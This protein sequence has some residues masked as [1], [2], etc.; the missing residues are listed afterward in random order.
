MTRRIERILPEF[1]D[2]FPRPMKTGVL[3]ISIP[4][5]TCGHLCACGCGEE[6]ITP[7]SPAQWALTYDGEASTLSPS[8]G[9]WSLPCRSHYF[10]RSGDIIWSQH[11]LETEIT[12]AR[13]ADH[14]A[15]EARIP[16]RA[17]RHW[18]HRVARRRR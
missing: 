13:R 10:I 11:Y 8:I 3:Y 14:A 12:E 4:Y 18:W 2:T 9:S 6:V 17:R 5:K 15:I 7:L 1:V 16:P